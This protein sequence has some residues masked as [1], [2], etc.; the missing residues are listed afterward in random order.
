MIPS[1]PDLFRAD[2]ECKRYTTLDSL[3]RYAE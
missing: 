1:D 3:E 2:T